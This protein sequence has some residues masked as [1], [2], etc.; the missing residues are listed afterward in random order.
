MRQIADY[1]IDRY[2]LQSASYWQGAGTACTTWREVATG[3]GETEFEALEDALESLAQ[4]DWETAQ[5]ENTLDDEV[6]VTDIL[7]EEYP[8]EFADD[9]D[10]NEFGAETYYYVVVYVK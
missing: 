8:N 10:N 3:I 7:R 2:G 6:T 9:D 4:Q 5:I 1:R